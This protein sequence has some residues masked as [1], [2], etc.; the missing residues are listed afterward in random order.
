MK[1]RPPWKKRYG[2][3]RQL[4]K[5]PRYNF[6]NKGPSSQ[7][8]G[9][10]SG[11]VWMWELDYNEY[12]ALK[13][14]S[15]WTVVLEKTLESPLD[16]K[17]KPVHPKGNQSWIFIGRTDAEA[18]TPIL[19]PP[20]VKNWLIWKD[21]DAGKDWRREKGTT[22]DEMVRWHRWLDGHEFEQTLGVGDGQGSLACCSPQGCKE[23]DMTERLNWTEGSVI[24]FGVAKTKKERTILSAQFPWGRNKVTE[25]STGLDG[26]RL[27]SV[28]SSAVN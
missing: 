1:L 26:K 22:E 23:S 8:Y 11:H 20:D 6:A 21:P 15:F 13:N 9:F 2:K 3:P 7:S 18:E 25:K 24:V 28:P 19:W 5:K 14:W 12:W 4:I 27:G 17:I 10:S 16:S